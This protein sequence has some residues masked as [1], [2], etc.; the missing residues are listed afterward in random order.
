M[1]TIARLCDLLAG[2]MICLWACLFLQ[3]KGNEEE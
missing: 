2:G 1:K 3:E